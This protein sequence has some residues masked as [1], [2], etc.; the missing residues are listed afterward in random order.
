MI[1]KS[2]FRLIL[3]I[4]MVSLLTTILS[5]QEKEKKKSKTLSEK[6]LL[7]LDRKAAMKVP[8]GAGF[9]IS[10][11]A[12]IPGRYS[13]VLSDSDG[14]HVSDSFAESQ[15]VVLEAI[16]EEARK[17]ALTDESAGTKKPVITRFYDKREPSFIVD[18]AKL[19]TYSQFFLTIK[20]LTTHLTVDAGTFK[21]GD[22]KAEVFFYKIL[23]KVQSRNSAPNQ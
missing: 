6:Q 10:P 2:V 15:V 21:R 11:I 1:Q 8:S 5:A 3:L 18:V 12:E 16:M 22:E 23:S 19:R 20:S 9:Y 4:L 7:E 13:L 17:F 14:R